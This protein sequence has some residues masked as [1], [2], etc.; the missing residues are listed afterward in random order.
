MTR[1]QDMHTILY[2]HPVGYLLIS[3][4]KVTY[5][6]VKSGRHHLNEEIK[7]DISNN[8]T[9]NQGGSEVNTEGKTSPLPQYSCQ[10]LNQNVIV[11]KQQP[12]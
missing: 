1:E 11:R 2:C 5:S 6:K 10:S 8:E 3:K 4:E 7:L 9:L 12:I